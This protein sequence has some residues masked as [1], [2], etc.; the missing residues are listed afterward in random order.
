MSDNF[1]YTQR[2]IEWVRRALGEAIL[3][4]KRERA[5]RFYEEATE[6]AQACGMTQADCHA[7]QA[8]VMSRESGVVAQESAGAYFTLLVLAHA[9]EVSLDWEL[10]KEFR[11][12]EDP[13][14]MARIRE[15]HRGKVLEGTSNVETIKET[16]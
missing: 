15:K 6:L 9:H 8:R 2:A 14:M 10:L 16:Q 13:A 7:I 12:V 5:M 11:R 4:S 3:K 1:M